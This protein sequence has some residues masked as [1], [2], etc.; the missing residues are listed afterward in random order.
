MELRS[1]GLW[2]LPTMSPSA[3]SC[4]GLIRPLKNRIFKN[5]SLEKGY[6]NILL[7]K[8]FS[9]NWYLFLKDFYL[10]LK[11]I[12]SQYREEIM[13]EK[14]HTKTQ[15]HG[16]TNQAGSRARIR[17]N[18]LFGLAAERRSSS[19]KGSYFCKKIICLAPDFCRWTCRRAG[20]AVAACYFEA[21]DFAS[22][23][24]LTFFFFEKIIKSKRISQRFNAS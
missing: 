19:E 13:L 4:P 22:S 9:Q 14:N 16:R 20:G 3:Y 5:C 12:F 18:R 1:G 7:R 17:K 23:E 2:S 8:Y 15:D 21:S 11:S 10:L 24:K 6:E